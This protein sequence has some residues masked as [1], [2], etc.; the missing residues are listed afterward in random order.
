MIAMLQY[1][2][3]VVALLA[4]IPVFSPYHSEFDTAML[5]IQTRTLPD[6][7][8]N[9]QMDHNRHKVVTRSKTLQND[10]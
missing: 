8:R 7:T 9:I 6:K 3:Q 10:L 2:L 1:L 4:K 5:Y